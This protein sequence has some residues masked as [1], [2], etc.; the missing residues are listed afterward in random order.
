MRSKGRRARA[1]LRAARSSVMR[2]V[3]RSRRS[4]CTAGGSLGSITPSIW[5]PA[6]ASRGGSRGTARTLGPS[7][8]LPPL[9]AP[10]AAGGGGEVLGEGPLAAGSSGAGIGAAAS[11]ALVEAAPWPRGGSFGSAGDGLAPGALDGAA[12]AAMVVLGAAPRPSSPAMAEEGANGG[13]QL[14]LWERAG[15]RM[16]RE[17]AGMGSHRA[18][19]LV[20]LAAAAPGLHHTGRQQRLPP[21]PTCAPAG[22]VQVSRVGRLCARRCFRQRSGCHDQAGNVQ[23]AKRICCGACWGRQRLAVGFAG[24]A[25]FDSAAV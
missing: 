20:A 12:G 16:L 7:G 9:P 3:C 2:T 17:G 24:C 1:H 22:C 19:L 4:F 14:D 5:G 11:V 13:A 21:V 8:G 15:R 23:W 10:A 18:A 6:A 25:A